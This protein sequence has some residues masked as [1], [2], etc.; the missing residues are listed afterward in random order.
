MLLQLINL[1][2]DSEGWTKALF[3]FP[4]QVIERWRWSTKA[5]LMHSCPE[6]GFVNSKAVLPI[7]QR[8][9]K[10]WE[11]WS[12][13][14]CS[15]GFLG[16]IGWRWEKPARTTVRRSWCDL[17]E[18]GNDY[19]LPPVNSGN[20]AR[21]TQ[22]TAH[23]E[24]DL[25]LSLHSRWSWELLNLNYPQFSLSVKVWSTDTSSRGCWEHRVAIHLT[26]WGVGAPEKTVLKGLPRPENLDL[27]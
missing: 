19:S 8:G 18:S 9:T 11:V 12:T 20:T 14:G 1:Y 26:Q 6:S 13:Q 25:G 21:S 15:G 24:W 27:P 22:E 16:A 5:A 7:H 17:G 10:P 4:G 23:L 3:I 2:R